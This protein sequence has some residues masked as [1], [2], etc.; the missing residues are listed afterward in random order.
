MDSANILSVISSAST[1]EIDLLSSVP[2]SATQET[3]G[4]KRSV[5]KTSG[6]AGIC[7]LSEEYVNDDRISQYQR[8]EQ[9]VARNSAYRR[10]SMMERK[11]YLTNEPETFNSS[12]AHTDRRKSMSAVMHHPLPDFKVS[13][14][15]IESASTLLSSCSS[16]A[17]E[18]DNK[19][20]DEQA[21]SFLKSSISADDYQLSS[22]I[23]CEN[24]AKNS[25]SSVTNR[26]RTFLMPVCYRKDTSDECFQNENTKMR[27]SSLA[28]NKFSAPKPSAL[29]NKNF[30]C[31]PHSIIRRKSCTLLTPP[32]S[33]GI[34]SQSNDD[35]LSGKKPLIRRRSSVTFGTVEEVNEHLVKTLRIP[36]IEEGYDKDESDSGA[37]NNSSDNPSPNNDGDDDDINERFVE[38]QEQLDYVEQI[39]TTKRRSKSLCS[40]NSSRFTVSKNLTFP[41][42]RRIDPCMMPHS[43]TS[44]DS[45]SA[46]NEALLAAVVP[47]KYPNYNIRSDSVDSGFSCASLSSGSSSEPSTPTERR[48]RSAS[49][50]VGLGAAGFF[51]HNDPG[52]YPSWLRSIKKLVALTKELKNSLDIG[53]A[54]ASLDDS[55]QAEVE[56]VCA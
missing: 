13:P 56:N 22:D 33:T 17:E 30:N 29:V 7:Q 50:A 44:S 31:Y 49:I 15:P 19:L 55:H 25:L 41:A 6:G 52:D 24:D 23:T 1:S 46:S 43:S 45:K 35:L 21:G 28:V 5:L 42:S 53:S 20:F 3:H 10:H 11:S 2:H 16:V 54:S 27:Y 48:C 36:S 12:H 32:L 34:E 40:G 26:D 14:P 18:P 38:E 8:M 37:A 4:E 39:R 9:E 51:P 47:E